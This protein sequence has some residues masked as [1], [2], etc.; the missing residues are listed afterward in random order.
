M[1]LQ[2]AQKDD[3]MKGSSDP[4]IF[5]P[6]L[7][8]NPQRGSAWEQ[9]IPI[10]Q[11]AYTIAR[12]IIPG[13][14][15]AVQEYRRVNTTEQ[16]GRQALMLSEKTAKTWAQEIA[17]L[18]STIKSGTRGDTTL[19]WHILYLTLDIRYCYEEGKHSHTLQT[20]EASLQKPLFKRVSWD[21]V[22]F[23]AHL[24][25]AYYS[26]RL[27][28]Q[29]LSLGQPTKILPELWDMLSSL[30]PLA[31][32]PDIDNTL[33]LLRKSS[34]TRIYDTVA[35][36]V[37]LPKVDVGVKP[38]RTAK[39]KK[40]KVIKENSPKTKARVTKPGTRNMFDILSHHS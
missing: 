4:K 3:Q 18:M 21:T 5:L 32:C 8:E 40:R 28:K 22:H 39:D 24:Q 12:W 6:I 14:S 33:E 26:F 13:P 9:S 19:A 16:R 31:E 25:A 27:L 34:E 17:R 36:F 23:V 7:L 29:V 15:S 10:R 2:L 37:P 1:V 30:P 11:L 38:K 20:L 35:K